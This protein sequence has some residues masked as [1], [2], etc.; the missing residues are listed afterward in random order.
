VSARV[1]LADSSVARSWP[2]FAKIASMVQRLREAGRDLRL[3]VPAIAHTEIVFALRRKKGAGFD[4]QQVM[5][6]LQ[7]R[8]V[9]IEALDSAAAE[10]VATVLS[11]WFPNDDA[12]KAAKTNGNLD[13]HIAAHAESLENATLLVHDK[14]PEFA[15][16]SKPI[17]ADALIAQLDA[18]FASLEG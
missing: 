9:V 4:A 15:N 10:K 5:G 11:L 6:P 17:S 7:Q 14:G 13:W 3:V 8:G 12:W 1:I 16:V 18:E 2:T